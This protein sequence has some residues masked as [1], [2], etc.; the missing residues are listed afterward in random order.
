[1]FYK[2]VIAV[3][4]GFFYITTGNLLA[5]DQK[6]A[7][8][9]YI[10]YQ[11]NNLA[12][13]AK[14]E[15]LK[16]LSFNEM[17]DSKKGLNYAVELIDLSRQA[18]NKKYLRVGYFLKGTKSRLLAKMDEA[19]AAYF[20]SAEMAGEMHNL[21]AAGESYSCIAD[22]YS[23][24]G[25][26]STSSIY[27]NKAISALR[28]SNDSTSL[29]S[30]L[31][32]AGDEFL[33]AKKYDTAFLYAVEA[34]A[35][36][37]TLH[38][39]S[40]IGYSLGNIG[41]VYASTG[42]NNLAEENINEAIRILEGTGDYYPICE[43]L[44]SMADVYLNK[45]DN[46]SALNYAL[47]SFHLAEQYGLKEQVANASL[48]LSEIYKKAGNPEE[49]FSFYKKNIEYRD[50]II[51]NTSLQKMADMRTNYEVSQKQVEV[52]LLSQQ[53]RN[54]KNI[55]ISLAVIL[56]LTIFIVGILIRN[57]QHKQKAYQI[58]NLQK[59]A[60]DEQK[61]KAEN[62]LDEL[63]ATQKQLI[64]SAKMASLGEV[65]A[66]I[67]HEIQ[68][69][70]NFV[71]NFSELSIELLD[72]LKEATVNRL[73]GS[74][75]TDAHEIINELAGNLKKINDHGKR[76]DAIV[77]GMLQHSR[78][79]TGK[80]EFT[81]INALADECLRL[82]Y[83]G[84]RAKD[85]AFSVSSI[86]NFDESIGKIAVIT[87][88]IA[89]VFLNLYNNAFYEVNMKKKQSKVAFEPL[90]SVSTK[91]VGNNIEISVKD[92][93]IGIP[94]KLL[95][96]IF[97]PFFTTKPTGQGTGL[98]LSLSYDIIK[99]H[100]GELKVETEEGTFSEFIIQL[101]IGKNNEYAA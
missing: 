93:G 41:M 39:P 30:A 21:K 8:S 38:Y 46:K 100:G 73:P 87:Q 50:S 3:V 78:G 77:K 36:F 43:Y 47:R 57:N 51:N 19:L 29:A 48:K 58:L 64:H 59:L 95:D 79:N 54:Q 13:T 91:R 75:K 60:T 33:K 65:T 99:A 2:R 18:G 84:F 25:N 96:K 69:P 90:V 20:K 56:G 5:Q 32:N 67:A 9:L 27:Y 92:N 34:K 15:L 71:N 52:D 14:F 11:Q 17:R 74:N 42:K 53:K 62:A 89:R 94:Q 66:G 63:Q 37:D 1:M 22:I 61:M 81:D 26:H 70:L 68:N 12:D 55:L 80:K 28:Q 76:A 24:A 31:L 23:S 35:I 16:D 6:I 72:E 7:D 88:D 10:I 40:G 82:S 44:V 85:K 98:G 45:E 83:H 4:V 49:A 97:Q 86:T 101:P